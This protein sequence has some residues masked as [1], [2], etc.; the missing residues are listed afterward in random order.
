MFKSIID[1]HKEN[2][3]EKNKKM[4][5]LEQKIINRSLPDFS[6]QVFSKINEGNEAIISNQKEID[7]KCKDIRNEWRKFNEEVNKWNNLVL[8]LDKALY[9]LGDVQKWSQNIQ[10]QVEEVINHVNGDK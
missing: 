10:T 5:E 3:R 8:D 1:E 2:Q 6:D 9:E 7:K 4:K